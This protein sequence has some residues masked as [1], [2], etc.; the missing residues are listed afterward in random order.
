MIIRTFLAAIAVVAVPAALVLAAEP[1]AKADYS[2]KKVCDTNTPTGS[3]L[4]SVRRCRTPAERREHQKESRDVVDRI[5]LLK[6][7]ICGPD[8]GRGN[9]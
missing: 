5:Q 7:T 9:C 2:T 6:P 4:G 1:D 8:T 3:R